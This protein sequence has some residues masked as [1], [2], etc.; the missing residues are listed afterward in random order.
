MFTSHKAKDPLFF[1]TA[2]I[3]E[4]SSRNI[5]NKI[6]NILNLKQYDI[7]NIKTGLRANWWRYLP[8]C[9]KLATGIIRESGVTLFL[10][11]AF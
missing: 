10:Y 3:K 4:R 2:N 5:T 7:Q 11:M 6:N 1:Q 8:N 9:Q